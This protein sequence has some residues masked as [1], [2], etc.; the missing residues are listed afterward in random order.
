MM[1]AT[2]MGD[3]WLWLAVGTALLLGGDGWRRV[4]AACALAAGASSAALVVLKRRFRRPRPCDGPLAAR[5][6]VRPSPYAA[7]IP[8][9]RFSFPSGHS[10]NAFA[11]GTVLALAA[12][13]ALVPILVAAVSVAAS[14]VLLGLH[15][16][17]DVVAGS[18]LGALIGLGSYGVLI[19]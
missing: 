3:G 7:L 15:F 1:W 10:M 14:R 17:S 13:W 18:L 8:S 19:R 5:P 11:I 4:F 9:D 16:L 2:R 12:P 6:P